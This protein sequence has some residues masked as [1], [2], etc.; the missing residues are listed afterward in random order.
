[1]EAAAKIGVD[2]PAV[3]DKDILGDQVLIQEVVEVVVLAD[4]VEMQITVQV[5]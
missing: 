5:A 3:L 2:L 1:M 4:L